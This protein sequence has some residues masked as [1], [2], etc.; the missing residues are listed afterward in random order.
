MPARSWNALYQCN[1]TNAGDGILKEEWFTHWDNLPDEKMIKRRFVSFDCANTAGKRSDYTVGTAWMETYDKR[2]FLTDIVRVRV[3]FPDLL[4]TVN[5]FATRARASSILVED[6]GH[7]KALLQ[8][9][10]GKMAAPLIGIN[11]Y[12]RNK[13]MRFDEISP[14]FEA[15]TVLLP[16]RHELLAEVERELLEFPNGSKDD[17][18]DS[19]THALRWARGNTVRRG[20]KKLAGAY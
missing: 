4:K 9:Y 1:P 14:M 11:P 16:K 17:I 18:V 15:G 19:C 12:N 7:G 20:T 13:E 10:K 3:E 6:A 2:Y 5:E 8:G